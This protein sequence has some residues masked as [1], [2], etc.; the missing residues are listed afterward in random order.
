[1]NIIPQTPPIV[2]WTEHK[3]RNQFVAN[4]MIAAGFTKRG[5]IM[6][7]CGTMLQMKS[8]PDCG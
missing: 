1:M 7:D 4:R 2:K 5:R 6:L 8:C 3:I